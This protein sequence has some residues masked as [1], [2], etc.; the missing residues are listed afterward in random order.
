MTDNKNP[1][2]DCHKRH[3]WAGSD[4]FPAQGFKHVFPPMHR[5]RATCLVHTPTDPQLL[6]IGIQR[7]ALRAGGCAPAKKE[8]DRHRSRRVFRSKTQVRQPLSPAGKGAKVLRLPTVS[9]LAH[10]SL[11][12]TAMASIGARHSYRNL[13]CIHTQQKRGMVFV[14]AVIA[15]LAARRS[16]NPKVV[17]SILT[18]RRQ[19]GP[20]RDA[21]RKKGILQ[22]ALLR[23]GRG[24]FEILLNALR[25]QPSSVVHPCRPV[26]LN[27]P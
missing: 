12:Y 23:S 9:V 27:S 24:V 26:D 1:Y 2:T 16:H 6:Y 15:Q 25:G 11:V 5:L 14:N 13:F 4:L 8:R 22:T 18:H 20:S 7:S 3:W 19:A 17:S 21:G 10:C